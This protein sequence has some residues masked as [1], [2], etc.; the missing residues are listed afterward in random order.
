MS[1]STPGHIK[2]SLQI[3]LAGMFGGMAPNLAG[4]AQNVVGN[5]QAEFGYLVADIGM[6]IGTIILGLIGGGLVF[7][8][9]ETHTNKAVALGAAAPALV[10]GMANGSPERQEQKAHQADPAAV[11]EQIGYVDPGWPNVVSVWNASAPAGAR[12]DTFQRSNSR[13][14]HLS[15]LEAVESSDID[16]IA[17]VPGDGDRQHEE[18]ARHVDPD[19]GTVAIPSSAVEIY[20]RVDEMQSNRLQLSDIVNDTVTVELTVVRRGI[21]SG[22]A[23]ALGRRVSKRKIEI[24]FASPDGRGHPE[25]EEG[26]SRYE[27]SRNRA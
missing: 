25:A 15:G 10:L 22:I 6:W 16:L 20:L 4:M 12:L 17:V 9:K 7:F 2:G 19:G 26:S 11:V 23:R 18:L 1:P 3:M 27:A 13:Y 8:Y 24:R 14:V 5:A 21:R